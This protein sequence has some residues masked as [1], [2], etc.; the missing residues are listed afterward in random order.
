MRKTRWR[1]REILKPLFYPL[2]SY[3]LWLFE[4][5][6]TL[7]Q[8]NWYRYKKRTEYSGSLELTWRIFE[9][10]PSDDNEMFQSTGSRVFRMN[11]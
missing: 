6:A 9:E 10:I 8:I 3:E 2:D 11:T 1:L 5:G 4:I 7:Q